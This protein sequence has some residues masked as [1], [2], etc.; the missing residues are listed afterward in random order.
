MKKFSNP[1][2]PPWIVMFTV[3]VF[4]VK[5]LEDHA[6][7]LLYTLAVLGLYYL[8]R[9]D[10][11]LTIIIHWNLLGMAAGLLLLWQNCAR[12]QWEIAAD[13]GSGTRDKKAPP[14]PSRIRR[15]AGRRSAVSRS[16]LQCRK[17]AAR[18]PPSPGTGR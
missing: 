7:L 6:F 16:L 1:M 12:S 18:T 2:L 13:S 17:A 3:F 9:E 11:T 4:F 5:G 14:G 15:G 10:R 8:S